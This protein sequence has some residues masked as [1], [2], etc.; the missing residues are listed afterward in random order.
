MRKESYKNKPP[1]EDVVFD[2][3]INNSVSAYEFTGMLPTLPTNEAE[4]ES[5]MDIMDYSPKTVDIFAENKNK[6]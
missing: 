3:D 1:R 6:I 4:E 2:L 5:Y